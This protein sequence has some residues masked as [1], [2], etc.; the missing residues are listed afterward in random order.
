MILAPKFLFLEPFSTIVRIVQ[1]SYTLWLMPNAQYE[2]CNTRNGD[3][4]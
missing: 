3:S 4:L 1:N 2:I